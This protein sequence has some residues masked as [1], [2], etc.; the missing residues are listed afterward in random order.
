MSVSREVL[1]AA[2]TGELPPEEQ[3][4]LPRDV[5]RLIEL[6]DQAVE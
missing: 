2:H 5:E 6:H 4:E 3:D 1:Y